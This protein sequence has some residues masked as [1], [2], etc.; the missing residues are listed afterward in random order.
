MLFQRG[1]ML[2]KVNKFQDARIQ[3]E[4]AL[5]IARQDKNKHLQIRAQLQLSRVYLEENADLAKSVATEAIDL[6]Q[7]ENLRNLAVNGLIDFGYTFVHR[8]EYEEAGRYFKQALDFA[9]AD[10]ARRSKARA[11]LA[12]GLLNVQQANDDEGIRQLDQ[13]LEFYQPS[14]YRKETSIAL[15]MLGRAQRNKG[16][17][18]EA[19]KIFTQQER[20]S[21]ELG[22][23]AMV[24][25]ANLSLALTL[26]GE[27]ERYPEALP[28]IEES[29][30][31]NQS[32]GILINAGFDEMNRAGMLWQLGRYGEATAS[33]NNALSIASRPEAGNKALHAWVH[34]T[35]AQI[36]L[37]KRNLAQARKRAQ[38]AME[39]AGTEYRDLIVQA[40]FTTG[41]AQALSGETRPAIKAC[42]EALAVARETKSPASV[43]SALLAL[44]QAMLIADDAKGALAA[45]LQAQEM[46]ARAGRMDSEWRALLVAALAS[47]RIGNRSEASDYASRANIQL[48]ALQQKWDAQAFGGYAR[49]PDIQS[50]RNQLAQILTMNK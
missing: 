44:S 16:N 15:T 7:A 35:Y 40:K 47:Q 33:L 14:G 30:K 18:E 11:R 28:Y 4:K 3:L 29:Y 36:A 21:K 37:S 27:Q 38:R 48:S 12:L 43:S 24:A 22:D 46:F 5:D 2:G 26:G 23:S 41:L 42:E 13:A 31:I 50:Y 20:L 34:M 10:K 25:D 8:G 9:I 45:A 39:L 19:I 17:Y 49:R 32:L 1:T 6:A